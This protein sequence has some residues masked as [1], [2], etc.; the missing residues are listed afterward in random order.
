MNKKN[1]EEKKLMYYLKK[2]SMYLLAFKPLG[3]I[4]GISFFLLGEWLAIRNFP[5]YPSVILIIGSALIAFSGSLLNNIFDKSLDVFS[6]KPT[7]LIFKYIKE[8]EMKIN[9]IILLILGLI[10]FLLVNYK[11]FLIGVFI[12]ILSIIYSA[13]PLRLKTKPPFDSIINS[14]ILGPLPFL[15]G[16]I[17]SNRNIDLNTLI[18]TLIFYVFI[19]AFVLIYTVTDVKNDREYGI[20]T[21]CTKIGI[22]TSLYLAVILFTVSLI[23]S[24][25]IFGLKSEFTISMLISSAPFIAIIVFGYKYASGLSFITHIMWMLSFSILIFLETK[26]II[27]VFLIVI[28]IVWILYGMIILP[29]II[30]PTIYKAKK[31]VKP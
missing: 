3:W 13:P 21:T 24:I 5:L 10:L 4:T 25:Y 20:E 6:R 7:I 28:T 23:A 2:I 14:L 8:K 1:Q 27:P 12:G 9:S 22:K 15:L 26:E 18:Y 19:K 17:A 31:G 16:W 29:K 11:V 30:F